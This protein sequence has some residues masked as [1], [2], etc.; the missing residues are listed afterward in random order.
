MSDHDSI[1]HASTTA[2]SAGSA[3]SCTATAG[4]SSWPGSAA[5]RRPRPQPAA[6]RRPSR[7]TSPPRARESEPRPRSVLEQRFAGRDRRHGRRVVWKAA[8]G[9][10][11]AADRAAARAARSS[12]GRAA[13]RRASGRAGPTRVAPDGKIAVADARSSTAACGTLPD[14]TG[15]EAHRRW[16][17]ATRGDGLPSQLGG[18]ADPQ[19]RG[20]QRGREGF[21]LLA[22]A[23]VLLVAF[24]TVVA[25]GLPLVDRAVRPRRSRLARSACSPRV[26]AR[27]RLRAGGRRDDRHRRR[28]RLRAADRSPASARRWRAAP[29]S[30]RRDRR[31]RSA[32]AGR[33]VLVAG[34]TV[35]HLAAR[36]V[37]HGRRPTCTASRCRRQPRRCSSSLA[38]AV[39]L[40]PA[41]LGCAGPRVEPAAHP[42]PRPRAARSSR[43]EPARC[44]G[45][46]GVQRRPWTAADRRRG[47]RARPRRA[48]ARPAARLPRRRQRPGRHARPAPP[49][50]SPSEGFGPGAN[51]P[52]LAR[53]RP[54]AAASDAAA[55]DP[56][57]RA[58]RAD[59]GRRLRLARR[60]VNPD[61]RAAI[62]TVAPTQ[63][64]RR[65][66]RR[67]TL[68][69]APA[70]RRRA[71]ARRRQRRD[72]A[73]S[74]ARPRASSTRATLVGA[75]GCRCFI[76]GVVGLS[77]LLLLIAFRSPLVALKAARDEPAV[78]RRGLRR[79]RAVRRAAAGSAAACSA[80]TRA[81]PGP[82]VHPR[83]DVRD[84]VRAVDGLRGLPALAH[85]R[86]VPAATATRRAR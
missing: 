57:A 18:D 71:G 29:T 67:P 82:A 3:P 80:S 56:L 81:T 84:P 33:C 26:I 83:D 35:R 86:G 62:L 34:S 60:S 11:G 24:G 75:A 8:A 37:P 31:G 59:R 38:A 16:P 53:R 77:F 9:A 2:G 44:A 76:G 21:G 46:A 50:T 20:R 7:P 10:T 23:I 43:P 41:L 19:G 55:L 51:G 54:A 36:P 1:D 69:A 4:A 45:A 85:P 64:R 40:L 78:G 13:R 12:P 32:T 47:R 63:R 74:A 48:G 17:T 68:V 15:H 58:A 52:L 5:D 27:A 6:A 42:G 70:R 49:T 22:A 73:T 39:T 28:H 14:S 66:R 79:R 65:T 30:Q 25:A 72:R 61:G